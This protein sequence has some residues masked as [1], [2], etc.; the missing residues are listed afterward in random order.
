MNQEERDLALVWGTEL[1]KIFSP[2]IDILQT[3]W[4]KLDNASPEHQ[5][6]LAAAF[7]ER[8]EKEGKWNVKQKKKKQFE[9]VKKVKEI[10]GLP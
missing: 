3:V 9:K 5:K 2:E 6:A 1:A 10:L 7:R 4:P 8:W